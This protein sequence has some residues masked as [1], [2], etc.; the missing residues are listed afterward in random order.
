MQAKFAEEGYEKLSVVQRYEICL[1][2][3]SFPSS[4]FILGILETLFEMT[5]RR[6]SLMHRYAFL[7]WD[8]NLIFFQTLH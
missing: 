1:R 8:A 5:M 7:V 2:C 6:V 3:S 4:P